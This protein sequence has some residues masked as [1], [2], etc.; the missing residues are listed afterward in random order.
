MALALMAML[1]CHGDALAQ[2]AFEREIESVVFVPKGQ[3]ITGLSLSYSQS[4]QNKY[5]FLILE[6]ISG[7]TY[8]FKVSPMLMFA[9]KN[10]M[11]AG[12]FALADQIGDCRHCA[13]FGDGL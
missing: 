4:A 2:D 6:G 13:R 10:D 12:L 3:W 9:F 7:D 11:A 8:T 1:T 5:Q